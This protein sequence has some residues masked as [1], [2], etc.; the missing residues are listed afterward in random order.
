MRPVACFALGRA[1]LRGSRTTAMRQASAAALSCRLNRAGVV[2]S[3]ARGVCFPA[4]VFDRMP[5]KLDWPHHDLE[6]A[7]A[8]GQP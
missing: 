6:A 4:E 7:L 5:G 2:P 8:S 1:R 3:G